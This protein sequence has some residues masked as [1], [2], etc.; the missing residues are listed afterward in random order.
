MIS[1][2]NAIIVM[3]HV[4]LNFHSKIPESSHLFQMC[5]FV[6]CCFCQCATSAEASALDM[7]LIPFGN[8][9]DHSLD[10]LKATGTSVPK[11][12]LARA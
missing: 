12:S 7:F 5:G 3:N 4:T 10:F 6:A 1:M 2:A 11:C 9:S 8:H